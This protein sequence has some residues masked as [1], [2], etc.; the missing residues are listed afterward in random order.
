VIWLTV[1]VLIVFVGISV[2]GLRRVLAIFS[3]AW[4]LRLCGGVLFLASVFVALTAIGGG[5]TLAL[6]VDK[7]PP[8]W[9]VGTPFR[10]YVIPGLI[11]AVVVGGSAAAA[12]VASLLKRDMGTLVSMLAGAILLG[13]LLGERVILPSRAFVPQFWWLEALY[14]ASALLMVLPALAV[15]LSTP[16]RS[17]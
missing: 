11:L 14:I 16:K 17:E 10:S 13:W 7:F 8:D 3:G 9:L 1:L 5:V 6:G 15:W 12:T 4:L 2:V